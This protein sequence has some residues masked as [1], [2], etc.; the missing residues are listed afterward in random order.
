M[1][2]PHEQSMTSSGESRLSRPD[3]VVDPVCG[4][5][6]N[7]QTAKF[8]HTHGGTE[9]YFCSRS[10]RAKFAADPTRFL[11]SGKETQTD[12]THSCCT[13]VEKK[14]PAA[15]P[16]GTTYPCPMHPEIV[17]DAPGSCPKCGMA[18]EPLGVAAEEEANPEL[19]DMSR[20]FWVSVALTLPL[21]VLA[22]AHMVWPA[23]FQAWVPG[24]ALAF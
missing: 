20:R 23:W 15:A 3:A 8:T 16:P 22:M 4:M 2:G 6:V 5:M 18:L 1:E 21:F 19:A 14:P 24:R 9:Y 11:A 12:A 7:P 13:T 10:C 17:R